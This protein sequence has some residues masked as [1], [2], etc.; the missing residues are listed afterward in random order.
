MRRI[1]NITVL[2]LCVM[3]AL[4]FV[5]GRAEASEAREGVYVY[6]GAELFSHTERQ[7]LAEYLEKCGQKAGIGIYV[8]TSDNSESGASDRY[9]EDF[10][11]SGYDSGAS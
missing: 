6:D 7:R 11:D 5:P 9:L 8:L 2:L 1:R 4:L 3:L 10:Y